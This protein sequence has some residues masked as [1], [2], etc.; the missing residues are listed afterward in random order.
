MKLLIL[1][2]NS[3]V[4]IDG[5]PRTGI[6]LSSLPP[7]TRIVVWD[8]TNGHLEFSQD[9]K[10]IC[11]PNEPVTD[12]SLFQTVIDGWNALTPPVIPPTL[13]EV[14][15]SQSA[16]VSAACAAA[17]TGGFTSSALGSSY[18]YPSQT[19]DQQ[20]LAANV[21]SSLLPSGQV[22]GWT[23]PQLCATQPAAPALPVWAYMDH[24]AAQIQQ[25]GND[26]KA[27][28]MANLLKNKNLQDQISNAATVAD[29][30]A[31]VW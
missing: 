26:G 29:V 19:T 10:G 28:I 22:A 6:D 4:S 31:I 1:V 18:T 11:A 15:A 13:D 8:G 16:L 9:A 25:V 5:E 3:I 23:T 2:E 14:K 12:T 20:N 24:T 27:A 7:L 17:I 21:L 30:Q